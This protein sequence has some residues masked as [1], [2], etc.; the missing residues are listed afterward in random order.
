MAGQ[1]AA[2]RSDARSWARSILDDRAR[3]FR[4]WSS[5]LGVLHQFG[6][7]A[8][9]SFCGILRP[10][11]RVGRRLGS[12]RIRTH[13][14]TETISLSPAAGVGRPARPRTTLSLGCATRTPSPLRPLGTRLPD[15]APWEGTSAAQGQQITDRPE[16]V[17]PRYRILENLLIEVERINP[18]RMNC[19]ATDTVTRLRLYGVADDELRSVEK[20]MDGINPLSTPAQLLPYRRALDKRETLAF[21]ARSQSTM[22]ERRQPPR[23]RLVLTWNVYERQCRTSIGGSGEGGSSRPSNASLSCDD[24]MSAMI[25]WCSRLN[26]TT[27][28]KSG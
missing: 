12:H 10:R 27:R 1:L 14:R 17:F 19:I 22:D 16:D 3:P 25:G 11:G 5:D 8:S 21:A 2:H 24:R 4:G 13:R 15:G 26:S 20:W 7:A 28:S 23:S 18:T 6:V 9:R